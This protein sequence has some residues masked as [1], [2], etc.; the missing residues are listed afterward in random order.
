MRLKRVRIFGFKTFA[1][2]TEFDVHGGIA[3]VVGPNGC[4]KSNLVDA[5]LWG[6]G[7]GSAKQL[8]AHT[9]QDVIFAGSSRRKAVGYAE[10]SLL[11]DNEDGALP[12]DS[13]EV[14]ISRK[15]NR[16][17]ESEYR[18][19]RTQCRLRDVLEL[20]AD[21][22]LGRAGY[23]IVGQKEIDQA[24]AASPEDRRAWV[25]EAAG[26]Q[27]YRARKIESNRRLAQAVLHLERVTDILSE[28]ESQRE[29]LKEE[30]E[31][32]IRYKGI[33]ASLRGVESGLLI[34]EIAKAAKEL[35]D[36]NHKLQD[37]QAMA[38]KENALAE[39]ADE[40]SQIISA[41][42]RDMDRAAEATRALH[43]DALMAIERA[44]SAVRLG[45]Q[46][47]KAL[48]DIEQN[49]GEESGSTA[50]R[51][52]DALAE[53]DNLRKEL[54][55]DDAALKN[56]SVESAGA[57]QEANR[58]TEALQTCE[59]K[60]VEARERHNLKLKREAEIAHA[61]ERIKGIK[62]EL[63]GIDNT[64]PDLEK[65]VADAEAA[66]KEIADKIAAIEEDAR[67]VSAALQASLDQDRKDDE[68]KRTWLAEQSALQG[69]RQGLEM[70][71]ETHEGLTQGSRAVLEAVKG[72]LLP[73]RYL[74]VGEAISADPEYALAIET[75]LGNSSN[76]LICPHGD[77]AKAAITLLKEHRLG[78]ATFQPIPLMRPQ[79]RTSDL[80]DLLREAGVIGRAS[81]LVECRSEHRPVIDSLL[82][83]VLVVDLLEDALRLAKT[84]DWSRMVT[85]DGE[86]LHSSG[87]V[88]GGQ[89]AKQTYGLV[90]RK[91]DLAEIEK[92]IG[93]LEA[94]IREADRRI[95]KR[96]N[97]RQADEAKFTAFVA[98]RKEIEG[99]EKEARE[100]LNQLR[101][102][103]TSTMR[104]RQK[105]ESELAQ[106]GGKEHEDLPD[107]DLGALEEA[108]DNI[109]KQ[110]ASK[111]ADAESAEARLREADARVVQARLR[112]ELGEKRLHAAMEHD[113]LRARK[114]DNLGPEKHKTQVDIEASKRDHGSAT[115]A[116]AKLTHDLK[117]QAEARE[118]LLRT[119][120]ERQDQARKA[121]HSAQELLE[122]SHQAE[123]ARARADA[124]RAASTQRLM[125]EYGMSEEDALAQA[126]TT[127]VPKDA[128]SLVPRLRR[129]LRAMG[130]VNLGAVEAY[131][132]LTERSDEL[133]HQKADV[134]QGMS[135]IHAGIKELDK[136]T[137]DRFITTFE[138]VQAAFS[139]LFTRMFEG[140]EGHIGL[141]HPDEI[142]DTGIDIDVTLPGKKRQ[143]LEVL[144]G[145]ERSLCATAFLFALLKVKPSPL[146][147][148]DEVD[149]PL[150]GRNVERF[151]Q[152]LRDF[153][154]TVQFI[155]ITHNPVTIESAPVW[156][157]VTMQEPGVS[158]LVPARMPTL[159]SS[160]THE[161]ISV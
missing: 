122:S 69:R 133:T 118:T 72:G 76:D 24:L 45:E 131:E 66:H 61:G 43:Q 10:V 67:T 28:I 63:K 124:R 53:L 62:R 123:L 80:R 159:Q 155:V 54:E 52:E 50:K 41:K 106:L 57:G 160:V 16:A 81:D 75:A 6:L 97:A 37:A 40:E 139:E 78:R 90:Q 59:K 27:R 152:L 68:V 70:T 38:A 84:K 22:G 135:E 138:A 153:S 111:T 5:I 71:I 129:E 55:A 33:L 98:A 2:R 23:S 116:H 146:V 137:R 100:W 42:L 25:D 79:A 120:S 58:L 105:L 44:A 29:P 17:G 4:G 56:I 60:L 121:R 73:D 107:E 115:E 82:G 99:E 154:N 95:E 30:A 15:L 64:I 148:L 119:Q 47:L 108:R 77:D 49:L 156:L 19:N 51:V 91:S 13:P 31:Q 132:R 74:P 86:L 150:D 101:D 151:V 103:I 1:D 26:V 93:E 126:D 20:L 48:E 35:R 130:D 102:E 3:A 36:L 92:R 83:R 34:V 127:E 89:S 112:L 46:K 136:L 157:G 142:L 114:L 144:S 140:G 94:K 12:V 104:S 128:A 18:I 147:V 32:A 158:T 161:S 143:R 11:F 113:K 110:L 39:S 9:S 149:A 8:R 109:L 96:T 141:T 7:E 21:S 134:E 145:G 125:E 85:L 87:A 65:G 88:T 14:T 117:D